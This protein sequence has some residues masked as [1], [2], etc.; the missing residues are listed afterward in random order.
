MNQDNI[1]NYKMQMI[2]ALQESNGVVTTA[3]QSVKLHRSTFYKWMK[4][5]EQFKKD[6]EDIR[7]S[8]LDFVESKMFE[9]IQNGSDTMIIFFLKTQGKKRGYIERSQL[10]V[11]NTSP[12]FSG[13]TTEE[14]INLLNEN[15][16][17]S[18]E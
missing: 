3:I 6:V 15:D 7:E 14:I 10:D 17:N 4:E 5:D 12:D 1:D 8:A 13:L 11:H 2:E 16:T 18:I 9:R